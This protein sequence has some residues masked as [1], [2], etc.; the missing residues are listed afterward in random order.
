MIEDY[1][2]NGGLRSQLIPA[3]TTTIQEVSLKDEI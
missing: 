3:T 1:L 2:K